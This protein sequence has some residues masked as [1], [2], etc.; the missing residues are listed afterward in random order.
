MIV[1]LGN[2]ANKH[3]AITAVNNTSEV[4]NSKFKFEI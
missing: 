1:P 2:H 4:S 3:D